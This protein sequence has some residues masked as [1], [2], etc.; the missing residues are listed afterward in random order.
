M[1]ISKISFTIGGILITSSLFAQSSK[2]IKTEL[3]E[4]ILYTNSAE[5]NHHATVNLP[6]GSSELVFTHVANNIDENSIQIGS[7]P[8]VTVMSVR[9]AVNYIDSDV[10]S[11]AFVKAESYYN[12]ESLTLKTFQNQKATEESILKLLEN[13]QKI[14]GI[15]GS[16]TVDE[17]SKMANYYK[18]KYLE[19]K[20]NI[21]AL[22]DKII[23][24]QGIVNKA[25]IQLDEV[26]GQTTG[27]GGQLI[28]QVMNNQ[29][30]NQPFDITY[31]SSQ[32]S[33][34]ASY[35]LRTAT[36]TSPLEIL[37][38]AN[39]TQATGIDWK[40]VHL[41]LATGNPSQFG[42]APILNPW[43]LYYNQDNPMLMDRKEEVGYALD[44]AAVKGK[45]STLIRGISSINNYTQQ[46][47]NQLNTTFDIA[48]PYDIASNG[49]PHAVSLKEYE[50][51]AS[52]SY[53]TVPRLDPNVYLMAELTDYEKLN[54]MP[55][56][57]HVMFENMLVGTTVIDPNATVDTLKLSM[58]K[59]KM[60]SIKRDKINDLSQTKILGSS[61][62]QSLVYEITIKNNKKSN[63][64]I[65]LQDQI[66]V[67][68]DKS[69]EITLDEHDGADI[70][71]ETGIL[72]WQVDVPAGTTKKIRFGYSIKYP[73]DKQV[74]IY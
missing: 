25:K 4:V 47:E 39:V 12:R 32:A 19:V 57:A 15:N 6:T 34:Y 49:K 52:Y 37:Y 36:I 43:Q 72:K 30:G 71:Q 26:R 13:N 2:V 17:L 1:N 42:I 44:E 23:V 74:N 45:K 66:P 59:D 68:T 3:K 73:K 18:A 40:Q 38:K 41:T 58:G 8:A 54:L 56:T 16:T 53:L 67:S 9:S 5:L 64:T 20:S 48:I 28:V 27:S 46:T 24:Q 7:S 31:T 29:V 63:V 61:K 60:I 50:H 51:P 33:W 10:K 70:L 22:D 21:T 14:A 65:S 62:K 11:D 69:M 35:D 55:G